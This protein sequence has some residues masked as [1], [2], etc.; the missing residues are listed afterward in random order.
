MCGVVGIYSDNP[1]LTPHLA[2]YALYS[3]QHRGQESAGIA[4][5]DNGIKLHKNMGLVNDVFNEDILNRLRG[6]VAIGH[7]RYSTTGSSTLENSQPFVVRSRAGDIAISHN[8]NL[9][10]SHVLRSHLEMEGRIFHS[11]SDT[12][13]IAQL[14]AKYLISHSLEDSIKRITRELIGSFS[15]TLLINDVLIAYRDPLGIKPLCMGETENGLIFAS[16]SAAIDTLGGELTRD[17]KPG[18]MIVVK[19]GDV[20]SHQ[21]YK[22]SYM[23]KCVFEY[24]YF[25]RPDSVIDGRDVY[26]VRLRIGKRLAKEYP[27]EADLVSPV[28]DSGT[29]FAVGYSIESGI[30]YLEALIK[31]RYIGRTF[32]MPEQE[33]RESSV[34]LK[35]NA[36]RSN[37][38]GKKIVLVDDSIVRGTTSRRI[39]DM[40]R[41]AG[42][43]EVHVRIGSPP[44]IA[45]CYFGIDMATREELI[46]A[47]KSV[48]GVRFMINADSLGYLSLEG[49]LESVGLKEE[50]LCLACLTDLYP[51]EIPGEKCFIHQSSLIEF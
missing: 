24:I 23:A 18:E 8:G 32:I 3:L 44:I 19:D 34:R 16:E 49:L 2:Y 33:L 31:N 27:V 40:L 51:L 10:N 46:A 15:L 21:L 12:E 35:L 38:K 11:E 39:V 25:A 50:D 43:N 42:A 47:Y 13:V 48:E 4:S 9:V 5:Y 30:D 36:V 6:N 17:V 45:P 26:D 7:V 14:L 28:P 37:V 1:S 29:T 20:E 22:S 41:K